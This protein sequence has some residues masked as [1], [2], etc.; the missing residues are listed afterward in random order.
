MGL[1]VV[2]V[3]GD[4]VVVIDSALVAAVLAVVAATGCSS[5]SAA[6]GGPSLF[7]VISVDILNVARKTEIVNT[8]VW[9]CNRLRIAGCGWLLLVVCRDIFVCCCCCSLFV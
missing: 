4:A 5:E 7:C 8:V 9:S 3:I 6:A 1:V 2:V